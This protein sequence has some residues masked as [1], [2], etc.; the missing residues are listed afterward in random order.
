MKEI[1]GYFE[2]D[3]YSGCEFYPDALAVNCGRSAGLILIQ[4]RKYKKIYIP[5][6]MCASL[7]HSLD[8]YGIEYEHYHVN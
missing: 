8:N 4:L 2:L 1:G 5:D 7:R 3:E 6:F